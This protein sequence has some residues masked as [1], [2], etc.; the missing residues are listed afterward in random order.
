MYYYRLENLGGG[1]S[2]GS[3]NTLKRQITEEAICS[4]YGQGSMGSDGKW[5]WT[6]NESRLR[7][8]WKASRAS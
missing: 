8:E 3:F 5:T 4:G 6:D 1:K 7:C 2:S